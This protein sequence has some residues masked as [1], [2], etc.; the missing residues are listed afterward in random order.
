VVARIEVLRGPAAL[1]HGGSAVGGVVNAIDNRIPKGRLDGVSGA[2][3]TRFGGAA[4]ERAVSAVVETGGNGFALHAD[5]FSRRTDELR[6]PAFDRPLLRHDL[7]WLKSLGCSGDVMSGAGQSRSGAGPP[8]KHVCPIA[9][10]NLVLA[11]N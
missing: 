11:H 9:N 10:K 8:S 3:E 7:I 5:V 2:L 4:G 6:V 1:L